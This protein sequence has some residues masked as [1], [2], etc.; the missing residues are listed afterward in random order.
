MVRTE[1]LLFLFA[2]LCV[3]RGQILL[4]KYKSIPLQYR[5]RAEVDEQRQLEPRDTEL[6]VAL[7]AID[8]FFG[9]IFSPRITRI[10]AN[11]DSGAISWDS[12][13][14][15]HENR[16]S[17]LWKLKTENALSIPF[18]IADCRDSALQ[19]ID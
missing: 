19:F 8:Q 7:A 14:A 17:H 1:R 16:I 2:F 3:I 13:L 4:R 6:F 18:A 10:D 12:F 9:H 5:E 15:W 11:E